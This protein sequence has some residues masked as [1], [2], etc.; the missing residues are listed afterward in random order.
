MV[1]DEPF[2]HKYFIVHFCF[3]LTKLLNPFPFI[4]ACIHAS[5]GNT[6][7]KSKDY[8]KAL[9]ICQQTKRPVHFIVCHP[10]YSSYGN[11][12]NSECDDDDNATSNHQPAAADLMTLPW[13]PL[14]TLLQRNLYRLQAEGRYIPANAIADCCQRITA[15][16]PPNLST[17]SNDERT[18]EKHLVAIASPSSNGRGRGGRGRGRHNHHYH[19]RDNNRQQQRRPNNTL[20]RYSLTKHRLIQKENSSNNTYNS[21][22]THS[23]QNNREYNNNNRRNHRGSY[24]DN[25]GRGSNNNNRSR[26]NNNNDGRTSTNNNNNNNSSIRRE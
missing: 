2:L 7:S 10:A 18:V 26:F 12:G 14:E 9:E 3:G 4:N 16:I 6:N 5:R 11:S 23:D 8:E 13:L 24:N 25:P 15:M 20:F 22:R 1:S 19:H 21:H 17:N